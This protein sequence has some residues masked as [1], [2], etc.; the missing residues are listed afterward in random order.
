MEASSV[1]IM[2]AVWEFGDPYC[3]YW[4]YGGHTTVSHIKCKSVY[5]SVLGGSYFKSIKLEAVL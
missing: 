5:D 4:K 1:N 2:T 3:I